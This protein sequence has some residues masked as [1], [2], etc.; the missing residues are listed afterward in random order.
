MPS[1][2][3]SFND[4][5][6]SGQWG[7]TWIAALFAVAL[8]LGGM[9]VYWRSG[10]HVP[11]V[12]DDME[13]WSLHRSRVRGGEDDAI[14]LL[15][16]SRIQL[17]LSMEVLR[18]IFPDSN[19]LQ[20]AIDG[21]HPLAALRDLAE[22]T[23]FSGIVLCSITSMGFQ[24]QFRDDQQDYVAYFRKTSTVNRRLN[25]LISSFIQ[26]HL[27]IVDPYLKV[28]R[29][30]ERYIKSGKLPGPRYLITLHDRS[31][32]AD[33]SVINIENQYR[34]RIKRI[35]EIYEG[36]PPVPPEKWKAHAEEIRPLVE[37]IASRGGR[38]VFIRLPSSGE[39]WE[40]DEQFYP[41]KEYWDNISMLTGAI[42]IHF[43]DVDGMEK[44]HCPEGSHLDRRDAPGFTRA[45]AAELIKRGIR[46]VKS[47]P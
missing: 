37:K 26:E 29:L 10:G 15:G 13:L 1:S 45:L 30:I 33:Y 8:V 9:E 35:K 7:R 27:V 20:L 34:Y 6:F 39:H 25:R 24:R 40:I 16:A 28:K 38:V 5:V 3:S 46:E 19:I 21:K 11:G 32:L 17:D 31:R 4:R 14:V 41:R 12:V 36:N 2:I 23:E 18:E 43:K 47:L 42:T 22:N 44:F